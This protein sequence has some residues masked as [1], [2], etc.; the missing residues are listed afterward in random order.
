MLYN[1]TVTDYNF[2]PAW[3]TKI[4]E[5]L[6]TS[7]VV[8]PTSTLNPH[9]KYGQLFNYIIFYNTRKSNYK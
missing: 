9:L 6:A 3:D 5:G 8:P 7:R 2:K 1:I 4:V